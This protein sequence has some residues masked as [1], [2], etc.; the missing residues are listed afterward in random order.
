ML[1]FRSVFITWALFTALALTVQ[2]GDIVFKNSRA[3]ATLL[4]L[5]SSEGCSSCPPAEAWVSELK[6]SPGLFTEI[7]P[8]V[9]HVDYWDG[10]G[11]RDKFAKAVYTRRQRN[12]AATLGQDSVYTPEFVAGGREWRAWFDGDRQPH[13]NTPTTGA[14][15]L[16]VR[17]DGRQVIGSYIPGSPATGLSSYTL[18]VALL[19]TNI[20]SN[21]RG[22][23]NG[24][25]QL[26]HDFVV[27]DFTSAPLAKDRNFQ[28]G[29]VNLKPSTDDRPGALVAWVSSSYGKVVQVAG[30]FL[31]SSPPTLGTAAEN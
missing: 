27:L 30:G 14:L 29:P 20:R 24:G 1:R 28:S 4:E 26:L 21:V 12:Y 5:Y 2:A 9:F 16:Q 22:G 7:F 23:E 10:L 25:R 19:G 13:S 18:N 17:P 3:N 8:V 15:S 31:P 6:N 11:W